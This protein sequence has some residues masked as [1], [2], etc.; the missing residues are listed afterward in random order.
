MDR[1]ASFDGTEL[2]YSCAGDGPDVLLLHGF[3]ADHQI[4][5]VV[6]GVV[7]ALVR[8]DRR[9]I[10]FDARGHGKSDK[11]HDPSAYEDDAMVRDARALLDYLDVDHVDVVGYSMGSLV[12]RRLVP[13]EPRSRS[14]VL[15][16]IGG[17]SRGSRG[18]SP[19]RR[20]LLA[21]ALETDDADGITDPSARAFRA[22]AD[23]TGA[24]RLA[25]AAIQ[26]AATPTTRIPLEAI[27][28]PTLVIAGDRDDL[29]GSPQLLADRIPGAIARLISGTH[30]GAVAD[31]AFPAAIAEFV[32][33]AASS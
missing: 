7:D 20:A 3:A 30:L 22:F 13:N 15:G 10:A 11:P 21:A 8:A 9:V 31:P 27:T 16:G 4:N 24:D 26:R 29:A 18:F 6:P 2:A 14:C 23:S 12:S 17:R 25:L 33:N 1:F 5:W 28:V 19:E 32:T